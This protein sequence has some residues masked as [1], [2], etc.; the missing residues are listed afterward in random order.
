M[1]RGVELVR[2]SSEL[3]RFESAV[4]QPHPAL[5]QYVREYVGGSEDTHAPLCRRELP[6]DIAPVIINF[7][8]PFRLFDTSDPARY[9]EMR[10]FATGAFDTYVLVG[11]TGAYSCIQINFTV[12][13]ARLFLQRPLYDFANREVPL[14]D[15]LGRYGRMLEMQLFDAATWEERFDILDRAILER[16]STGRG[17][18]P[19]VSFA[20][21]QLLHRAGQVSIG[22]L[23]R[24]TG[25]SH[26]HFVSQFT[27]H[28]G[29]T[30][31]AM[32]RVLRFGRA[33]ELLQTTERGRFADIAYA[34]GYYDQA[35]FTRDF[36]S[37]AG[38]SP[39]A[40][41]ASRLPNRGG[42]VS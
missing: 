42:F 36:T 1:T 5:R 20:W 16:V 9:V 3:G 41:L 30:P 6:S 13:G 38:V 10:S 14:D 22:A 23:A 37:F 27:E 21:Q 12:L 34:C 15:A 31:K 8:A 33:A 29:L 11:T 7:G 2:H 35:H 39:T 17:V 40:L 28:I 24:H 32:G 18:P 25:W 19:A 4:A 26:R